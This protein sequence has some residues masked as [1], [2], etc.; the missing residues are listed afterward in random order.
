V[1]VVVDVVV[2][3]VVVV[4]VVD[5]AANADGW[6]IDAT[7]AA[8]TEHPAE[9]SMRVLGATFLPTVLIPAP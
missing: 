8:V 6:V 2:V 3:D 9:T 7:S 1:V 5:A 4:V